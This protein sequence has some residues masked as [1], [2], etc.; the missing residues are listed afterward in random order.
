M[1]G[2]E[3]KRA[4]VAGHSC[5]VYA[6]RPRSV[7]DLLVDARRWGDR[8]YLVQ[9]E[10]RL[11]RAAFKR[12]VARV[13]A[14]LRA[15]G[16]DAGDRV[17]LLGF[18]SIEW[19]VAFWALQAIGAV[20]ALGNA[21]WSDQEVR[22]AVAQVAPVLA[23]TDRDLGPALTRLTFADIRALA[24]NG[25]E[26]AL[27][28]APVAE[29]DLALIMFSSGTT[30]SAKGVLMSHRSVVANIQNLLL[31]TGRLPS[32]LPAD[33]PGTVSLL[34]VPLFHLAGIQVSLTT[35][36][37]G[38][39]AVFL[40]G[41]FDP[42]E[43]LRLI[44]A[45]RV[46]V[47]GSI[48]TMVSRVL[49]H[50]DFSAYDTSSV[51]SVPMGG[52]AVSAELRARVSEQFTGVKT[53]VGSLYGLTEAGGVLAAGSG[54]D[55][56]A[57]PGAVGRAL[58]VVELAIRNSGPDGVGEIIARTPTMTSGYLDDPEPITDP[59]GWVP[60]GDLGRLD[61]DGWLYVTGRSKDIIIRG[62]ENIAAAHVEQALLSHPEV[63]EAA[64]V[65]LP[66]PDLGEQVAAAVVLRPGAV[67]D[68]AS[69]REHA[70]S[71]LGRYEVPGAWWLHPGPLPT[72]PSGK[73]LRRVVRDEW[74]GLNAG[75]GRGPAAS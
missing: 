51:A 37:S 70:E 6:R 18:N 15:R 35:L 69:L 66:H 13:A 23:V 49:D 34:S 36:L 26:P 56:S 14:G 50:P 16:A 68:V 47:W 7:A 52:A 45:E 53:R 22:H 62:G 32:E 29:D 73:I 71:Q 27:V 67:S 24:A 42:G 25:S 10:R 3:V 21:W 39:R 8:E 43:V 33:H 40:P 9:G 1:W 11:S 46:R 17:L 38:G 60:T 4:D 58:P 2:R 55:I 30:G 64:V 48:P 44:E 54:A 61:R 63:L 74:P 65:G 20:P 12:A 57:R 75:N 59:D 19:V 28:P 72:N 41:K 5:L 31:L